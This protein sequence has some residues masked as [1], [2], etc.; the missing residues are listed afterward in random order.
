MDITLCGGLAG[1]F[2]RGLI[3]RALQRLW[4]Q[5]PISTGALLS[6]MEGPFT[7]NSER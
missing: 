4:R 1:E 2:S 6:I 5:A 3:Y 7:G